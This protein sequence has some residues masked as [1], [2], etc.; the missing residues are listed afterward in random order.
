MYLSMNTYLYE[1][2]AVPIVE[3]LDRIRKQGFLYIDYAAYRNGDPTTADGNTLTE[4]AARFKSGDMVCAQY[5]LANVEDFAHSDPKRRRAVIDYMKRCTEFALEI[6]G[7]ELMLW[8]GCGMLEPGIPHEQTWV[9]AV[10]TLREFGQWA[11]DRNLLI[12]L[13]VEPNNF[14]VV[15]TTVQMAKM[16]EDVWLP[17]IY[18]N[19]DIG[20]FSINREGPQSILKLAK[21]MLHVHLSETDTFAHTNSII[22]TGNVDYRAY[23]DVLYEL[24]I[25]ENCQRA[26]VP[27]TAGI[28]MGDEAGIGPDE[29]ERWITQSMA[30]IEQV[31]PELTKQ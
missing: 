28:E 31:M 23:L 2:A 22:G 27:C 11:L 26:G 25:E 16:I 29:P 4:A 20:H 17:N 21:R 10:N 14:A 13:E 5:H 19:I 6:G 18:S 8:W 30:Y 3:S 9:H 12:D 7:R 15:R 24:G 1:L